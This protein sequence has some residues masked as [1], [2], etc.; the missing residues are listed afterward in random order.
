MFPSKRESTS[1]DQSGEKLKVFVP[2]AS[3]ENYV[4]AKE[5]GAF[6]HLHPKT[7]MRL[8]REDSLPAYSFSEGTRHHW[9]FLI[10][11]LDIWMKSKV[12]SRLH[13]V[14]PCPANERRK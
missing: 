3:W 12:N 5:A 7:V 4:D 9:R 13:P 1:A 8:A 10:S 2:H 14:L 11:E 6:L